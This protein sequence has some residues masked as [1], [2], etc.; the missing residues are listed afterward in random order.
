MLTGKELGAAIEAA[1]LLKKVSKVELA[2]EFGV[3]PPSVQDWV[4]KGTIDKAKLPQLWGYFAEVV[5][6]SHW[7]LDEWPAGDVGIRRQTLGEAAMNMA[8]AVC[9][10]P[11]REMLS[12]MIAS[13]ILKGPRRDLARSIDALAPAARLNVPVVVAPNPADLI[14]RAFREA[15][16]RV[17]DQINT[18]EGAKLMADLRGGIEQEVAKSLRL[19]IDQ[20]RRALAARQSDQG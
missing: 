19:D 13:M 12:Q 7:G 1:R 2:R 9:N 10:T 15:F 14:D 16:Y 5:G 11:D 17:T 6:P 8:D 20:A 18:A 4:K 3:A